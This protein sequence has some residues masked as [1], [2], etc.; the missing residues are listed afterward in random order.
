LGRETR[1][2]KTTYHK[3]QCSVKIVGPFKNV[4]GGADMAA[5]KTAS[6]K[7]VKVVAKKKASPA[8]KKK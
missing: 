2:A 6:K 4:K 8:K 1:F 7:K 3:E 5:K